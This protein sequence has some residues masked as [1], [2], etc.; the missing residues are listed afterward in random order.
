[1]TKNPLAK[2]TIPGPRNDLDIKISNILLGLWSYL[3]CEHVMVLTSSSV[4]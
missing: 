4:D 2:A 3:F 1:M